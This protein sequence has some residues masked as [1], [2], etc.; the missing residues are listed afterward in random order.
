MINFYAG[1]DLG[2]AADYTALAIVE[3]LDVQPPIR[4]GSP[5]SQNKPCLHL[6]HLSRFDLGTPYPAIVQELSKVLAVPPLKGETRLIVDATGVGRPVVDLLRQNELQ[7]IAVT[8]TAG[9]AE[10]MLRWDDWRVPKRDLVANLEVLLQTE[11]L[12]MAKGMPL[13]ATLVGELLAFQ[14]RVTLSS[15]HD[16][17]GVWRE[18]VHDDLVLGVALACWHAIRP[19]GV[20]LA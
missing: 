16:S 2:Q 14:R 17:Y 15:A 20:F 1:L 10:L 11:R 19:Q 3:R 6:R 4:G 18:G 8:I 13:V 7:P 9:D 5:P 12:K